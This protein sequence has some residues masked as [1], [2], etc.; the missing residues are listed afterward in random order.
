MLQDG[1]EHPELQQRPR[2]GQAQDLRGRPA[3][4]GQPMEAERGR[5]LPAEQ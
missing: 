4:A 5:P 3:G 2:D 1:P